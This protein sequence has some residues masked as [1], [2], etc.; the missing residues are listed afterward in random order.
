M[1]T[2]ALVA[3]YSLCIGVGAVALL[4]LFFGVVW[5][6]GELEGERR[7]KAEAWAWKEVAYELTRSKSWFSEEPMECVF[8]DTLAEHIAYHGSVCISE[9]RDTWRRRKK[10]KGEVHKIFG[11]TSADASCNP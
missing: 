4:A 10:D 5:T 3:G 11:I 6:L 8:F 1:E 9:L 2:L 7:R